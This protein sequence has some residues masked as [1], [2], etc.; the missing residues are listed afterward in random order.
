MKLS[1]FVV[2]YNQEKYIRQ[3][4]DS[5]L[6]QK[7]DFDYE[8]VI[9]E[10]HGTDGTRAICEEYA[11]KYPQIRL[12]PLIENLGI[13]KNWQRVLSECK[14][15]YIAMCEGDDYW[16]DSNKLQI[17]MSFLEH[18]KEYPLCFHKVT[19]KT[20]S[21]SDKHIFEHLEERAYTD[22]EIYNK[23]TILTSSV[24]FRNDRQVYEFP[25]IIKF[26][27]TYLFLLILN[28]RKAFCLNI[29]ATTYRRTEQSQS[30]VLTPSLSKSLF[31]QYKYMVSQFPHLKDISIRLRNKY[32]NI[33]LDDKNDRDTLKFRLYKMWY[34]PQLLFSKFGGA[35]I[36]KYIPLWIRSMLK[37]K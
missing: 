28:K 1:V 29:N 23:W 20:D 16:T 37:F 35:T 25:S 2:T 24:M 19:V 4:L 10:D 5:I 9:G 8:V 13:T 3:C 36:L 21:L 30:A 34:E 7:V 12:L 17:Q 27:D 22:R 33:L 15:D 26:A 18:N 32:L 31:Y 14:G 11:A 6:M